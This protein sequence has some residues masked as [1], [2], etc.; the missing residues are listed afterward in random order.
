M[1]AFAVALDR[2]HAALDDVLTVLQKPFEV[3]VEFG[4]RLD[5]VLFQTLDGVERDEADE[6]ADAKFP[7][8][9]VSVAQNVVE[10]FV[11]LVPE[12]KVL[13]AHV[14]HRRADVCVVLEELRR[15]AL[16][17]LVLFREFERDAHEVEAEHPHPAGRVGL[18][19]A[20]AKR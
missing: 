6:R 16:V 10:K 2:R 4:E 15:E 20:R 18:F 11:A 13:P 19:E 1:D 14:L 5:P 9:A 7:V 3:R 8:G 17:R 12:L